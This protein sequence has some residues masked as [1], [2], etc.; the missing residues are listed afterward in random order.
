M[1]LAGWSLGAL[2]VTIV[3]T[4]GVGSPQAMGD[5]EGRCR[6]PGVVRCFSFDSPAEV[7]PYISR[8]TFVPVV[9][10]AVKASGA[11]SLRMM[12]PSNSGAN[13][14][15]AFS[16]NFTPGSLNFSGTNPYPIQF[17]EGQEFY[18]QWRQRF[19]PEFLG[20]S[21]TGGGGWKQAI[22]G[23]GDRPGVR[24]QS[25]TQLEIVTQNTN[26]RGFPQLYHSCGLK[27][28]RYEPL[29]EPYGSYD[30]KLQ[31]AVPSPY[32]L[33]S[34]RTVPPCVGY[35]ASQW[36]TFQVHV[37]VGT[38]YKNDGNYH[39]D[40]TIQLWVAE[41]GQPS[42][43]VISRGNY[44]IANQNSAAKYGK[45]W[46]LPYHTGKDASQAH[47]TAYVWYDDLIVSTRRIPDPVPAS[48]TRGP[49]ARNATVSTPTPAQ[50]LV[51]QST[52]DQR[53]GSAR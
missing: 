18:V 2:C 50:R 39:Q 22:I 15:G 4:P 11:G 37:K 7:A 40:S 49:A 47:P 8:G 13:S 45:I 1:K 10:T 24:A 5:F 44:D 42:K 25:C 48:R 32:C 6:G 26:Q 21:Y 20:T 34:K 31:N 28:D 12:I 51:G 17:G 52:P 43:L 3:L 53:S 29:E 9:D 36:M 35:K 38:W 46:L 19:S 33:Y 23:E 16:M 27:D 30:F 41:E 14:A